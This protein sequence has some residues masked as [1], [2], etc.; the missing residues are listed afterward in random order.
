MNTCVWC[1]NRVEDRDTVWIRKNLVFGHPFCSRRCASHWEAAKSNSNTATV[2]PT[3]SIEEIRLEQEERRL[4]GEKAD[5]EDKEN[6]QR[7]MD[8]VVKLYPY[9]KVIIPVYIILAIV[10]FFI[11]DRASKAIVLIGFVL[12]VIA[13]IWAYFTVPKDR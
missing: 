12:P 5:L 9:W 10:C 2:Q 3:R 11:A 6:A 8:I 13:V 4:M 1:N 7:I